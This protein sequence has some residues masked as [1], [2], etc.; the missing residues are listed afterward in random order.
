L[1]LTPVEEGANFLFGVSDSTMYLTAENAL[2]T[3]ENALACFV[4]Y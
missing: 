4:C 3:A 1:G 2:L